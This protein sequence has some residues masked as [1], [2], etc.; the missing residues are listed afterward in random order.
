LHVGNRGNILKGLKRLEDAVASY[1]SAIALTPYFGAYYNRGNTLRDLNRLDEAVASYE[2]AIALKSDHAE[3]YYNLAIALQD[4]KRFD[5]AISSFEKAIALELDMAKA[6]LGHGSALRELKRFEEA[7]LSYEKAIALNPDYA[8]SYYNRAI[9]LQD[10]KR[11]DEAISSFEKAIALELDMAKAWLGHGNALRELQRF[12]EAVLSY[13]KAIT[14]KPDYPEGYFNRAMALA[15][16]KRFDEAIAGYNE[17][18]V[19]SRESP[20]HWNSAAAHWNKSLL[21][22]MLGD[23]EGGWKLFEWRWGIRTELAKRSFAQPLW[24]GNNSLAQK[25]ILLYGEQGLGDAIQFCRYVKLVADLGARI[26]LQVPHPLSSVLASLSGVTQI[27]GEASPLPPFDYQCP[28]MSLPLAFKTNLSSIPA[29]IPYL[30]SDPEKSGFWKEKLGD[31]GK[32]RVGLVWSGGFRPNQPEVWSVN[33]RRNIPLAYFAPLKHADIDFYSLQK[34]QPAEAELA[35]LTLANWDGPNIID[36]TNLL[37]DFSDTAAFIEN[38]DL[39][40]SVDT[41][42]AHLAG[43]M[44]KPVWILNRFDSCWRWLLERSDSPWYPTAKLYRQE[45]AGDWSK[46]IQ[47]VKSDL[48]S[49]RP[50]RGEVKAAI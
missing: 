33:E 13:E 5:E 27:I 24:L 43:A 10:L 4:L 38:L 19:L 46:I 29:D 50:R 22:L 1:E 41:S 7:V 9:A 37:N 31:K 40:I 34:G 35:K 25:T 14:L 23:Y 16:L 12:E 18:I 47:Q 20:D 39:V 36:Y 30:K 17:A 49:F 3:S 45:T 15:D 48:A 44:G 42:T 8:E 6:W 11:F 26:I 21:L 32:L 28:L 2:K